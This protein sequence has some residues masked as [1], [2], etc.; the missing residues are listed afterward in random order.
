MVDTPKQ[1]PPSSNK[2]DIKRY[3]YL[4]GKKLREI[5][6]PN[7]IELSCIRCS[8]EDRWKDSVEK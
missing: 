7:G 4:L 5:L 8:I 6:V 1:N 3:L 2:L